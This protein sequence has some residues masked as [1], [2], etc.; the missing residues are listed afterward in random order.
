MSL[1]SRLV[2]VVFGL[3]I[4]GGLSHAQETRASLSGIV[5]DTSGSVVPGTVLQL[6]NAGTG[7]VQST[8][9]NEAGLYRFLFLDPG[10]YSVVATI[11]GFKTW[12]RDNIQ[13]T[14]AQ[15]ATLPVVLEIGSQTEKITVTAEAPL[16]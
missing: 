9:A 7:V 8:V 5:S 6:T 3:S 2:A 15:S 4:L 10:K 13:L 12:E 14:V 11:S 1:K 16:I